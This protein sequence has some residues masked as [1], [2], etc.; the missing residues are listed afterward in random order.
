MHDDVTRLRELSP[1][2]RALLERRL[3]A[4]SRT[5]EPIAVVGMA[6]RFPNAPNLDAFWKVVSEGQSTRT[7]IPPE[8]W[9]A[10]L[11]YDDDFDAPGKM[12]SK[13]GCFVDG[14]S[15]FDPVF[16][17]ITPREATRMDP[18]QRLLLEVAWQAMEHAGIAPEALSRSPTGVF[19][20][21]GQF[22]YK[23]V[24]A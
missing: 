11:L 2:K 14:V 7:E 24:I 18:Q 12:A 9:P 19:I 21:V 17:G 22:D 15:Q 10:A 3:A 5:T 23:S 6:C 8:R 20:G 4:E 16:F 13:W 1:Q